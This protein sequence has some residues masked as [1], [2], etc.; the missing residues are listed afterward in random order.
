MCLKD[1]IVEMPEEIE[2]IFVD[3]RMN[4]VQVRE[5]D[6]YVFQNEDVRAVF[7]I[8]REIFRGNFEKIAARYKDREIKSELVTVI[9]KITDST[10]LMRQGKNKEV[11][12]NMCTEIQTFGFLYTY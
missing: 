7:E 12:V 1:M 5:S 3:Y 9:G 4:L 6:S 10:E 8:S 2:R 11:S